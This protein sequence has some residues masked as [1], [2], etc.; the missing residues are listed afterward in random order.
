MVSSVF[1]ISFLITSCVLG[2]PEVSKP[3]LGTITG[4]TVSYNIG[5]NRSEEVDVFKGVPYAM[6]LT[7]DQRFQYAQPKP[8]VSDADPV[9]NALDFGFSCPQI[10]SPIKE[11]AEELYYGMNFGIYKIDEDCLTLN[12]Y[13]PNNRSGISLPVL[14]W[15]HGGAF[16]SGAGSDYDGGTLAAYADVVVVTINY[17]L[18]AFGFLTTENSTAQINVGLDDQLLALKWVHENIDAFGGDQSQITLAGAGAGAES[19]TYHMLQEENKEYFQRVI[20]LSGVISEDKIVKNPVEVANVFT[21]A[22]CESEDSTVECLKDLEIQE[23]L[24]GP[25]IDEGSILSYFGPTAEKEKESI[26]DLLK[27]SMQATNF[28]LMIGVTDADASIYIDFLKGENS[29][30]ISRSLFSE[31]VA[32]ISNFYDCCMELVSTII[33]N[34]YNDWTDPDSDVARLDKLTELLTDWFYIKP[35]TELNRARAASGSRQTYYMVFD[36]KTESSEEESSEDM[37]PYIFGNPF[38]SKTKDLFSV[39][40]R[41]LSHQMMEFVK[42]FVYFGNPSYGSRVQWDPYTSDEKYLYIS[43]ENNITTKERY[44]ADRMA[45]WLDTIP[46]LIEN[47]KMTVK[48]AQEVDV[49]GSTLSIEEAEDV[50]NGLVYALIAL[51][52]IGVLAATVL[53]A[54][55]NK[56]PVV[57]DMENKDQRSEIPSPPIYTPPSTLQKPKPELMAPPEETNSSYNNHT[58]AYDE[59][60]H[61]YDNQPAI[62]ELHTEPME[63][64]EPQRPVSFSTFSGTDSGVNEDEQERPDSALAA[65]DNLAYEDSP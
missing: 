38:Q 55:R 56:P 29:D 60:E 25:V 14:V 22:V 34:S 17:R 19:V 44:E 59:N 51:L 2:A 15:I 23:I 62:A 21:S 53:L 6:Q 4:S 33:S 7:K 1:F 16:L 26:D 13:R 3:G 20:A 9:F 43:I 47:L 41:I 50:I 65:L 54:Q 45:I 8:A 58:Y 32:T 31:T 49:L 5:N 28:D 61:V 35:V 64:Q 10:C 37:V 52:A 63:A 40:E 57:Y 42:N 36:H 30:G 18:G 39:E 24:E 48:G 27:T 46:Q 11:P 12:V